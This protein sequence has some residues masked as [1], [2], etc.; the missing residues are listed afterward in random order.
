MNI[1]DVR[2]VPSQQKLYEL[3]SD[4]GIHVGSIDS[5]IRFAIELQRLAKSDANNAIEVGLTYEGET[6]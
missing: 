1:R 4:Y 6:K 5:L 2:G 3:A